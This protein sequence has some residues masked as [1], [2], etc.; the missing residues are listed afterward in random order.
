MFS[1]GSFVPSKW[2]P[3]SSHSYWTVLP[4]QIPILYF[5]IMLRLACVPQPRTASLINFII[6][7]HHLTLFL[8][9]SCSARFSMDSI[10]VVSRM[11]DNM[12]NN[13]IDVDSP[14]R[15]YVYMHTC[16][17]MPPLGHHFPWHS[18][19]LCLDQ[20][21]CLWYSVLLILHNENVQCKEF[22]GSSRTWFPKGHIL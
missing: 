10:F 14:D 13:C 8:K 15:V 2:T 18:S 11:F 7:I 6:G 1:S 5:S 3:T 4:R 19:I 16:S 17:N 21:F 12:Q 20:V 9:L 22:E